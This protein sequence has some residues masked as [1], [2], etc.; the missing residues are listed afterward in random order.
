MPLSVLV[1]VLIGTSVTISSTFFSVSTLFPGLN[2]D[3][4]FEL[5]LQDDSTACLELCLCSVQICCS[6]LL[7]VDGIYSRSLE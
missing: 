4:Y 2:V 3:E 1:L 6:A 5:S 7:E